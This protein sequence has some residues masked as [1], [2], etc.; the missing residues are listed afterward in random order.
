[1]ILG[2]G[3]KKI[4]MEVNLNLHSDQALKHCIVSTSRTNASLG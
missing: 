1:M 4:D 3:E 2:L